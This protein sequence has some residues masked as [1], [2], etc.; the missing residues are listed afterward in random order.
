MR[1]KALFPCLIAFFLS[2][3]CLASAC[4]IEQVSEETCLCLVMWHKDGSIVLFNLDEM[5]KIIYSGDS[6][7]VKS[8]SIVEYEFQSIKKMTYSLE[9][10]EGINNLIFKQEKPFTNGD[11][12]ITFLPAE[13]DL[14]ITIILMNG[15]VVKDFVVRKGESSTISLHSFT[16]KMYMINVNGVTYKI[17]SR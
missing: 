2:W 11:E 16:E 15:M 4:P 5:P 14:H 6:V 13:E 12:T 8:S 17:K 1:V 7:I 3:A 10:P 9:D